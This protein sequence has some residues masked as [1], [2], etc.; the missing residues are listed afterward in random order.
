MLGFYETKAEFK[1]GF[2]LKA[3]HF[4]YAVR[5]KPLVKKLQL[6]TMLIIL[7]NTVYST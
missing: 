2:K 1:A 7:R 3:A 5:F 4:E 6:G